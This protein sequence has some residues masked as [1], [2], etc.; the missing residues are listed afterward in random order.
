MKRK[1]TNKQKAY[2]VEY[3]KNNVKQVK[4]ALNLT[5]DKDILDFLETIPNNNAYLKQLIREDMK[6]RS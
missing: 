2:M 3:Q 1:L 4:L 5:I 6:K